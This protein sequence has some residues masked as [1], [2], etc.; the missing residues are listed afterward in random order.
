[1]VNLVKDEL[2]KNPSNQNNNKSS[3]GYPEGEFYPLKRFPL[4]YSCLG[5][6]YKHFPIFAFIGFNDFI[7]YIYNLV[8]F[9]KVIKILFT[10]TADKT[11]IINNTTI[12]FFIIKRP[13][14]VEMGDS[15]YP[16]FF[17]IAL[18]LWRGP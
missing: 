8:V 4:F 1:M 16:L 12:P 15:I 10:L 13:L 18:E 11:L 2:G 17:K 6:T 14:S 3:N 9:I 5:D 7:T